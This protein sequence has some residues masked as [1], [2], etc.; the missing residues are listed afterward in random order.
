M[1]ADKGTLPVR[2]CLRIELEKKRKEKTKTQKY[3]MQKYER[4]K[5]KKGFFIKPKNG[6]ISEDVRFLSF[7]LER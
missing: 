5:H 4:V 3:E 1:D 2:P 7:S 6:E